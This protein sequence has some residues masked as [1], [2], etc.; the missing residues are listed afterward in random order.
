LL[1]VFGHKEVVVKGQMA[2]VLFAFGPQ[3]D[4]NYGVWC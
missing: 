1:E 3:R 2:T 4:D